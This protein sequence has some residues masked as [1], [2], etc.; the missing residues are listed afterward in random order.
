M[1]LIFYIL[2]DKRHSLYLA[3]GAYDLNVL[4]G[5]Q[6]FLAYYEALDAELATSLFHHATALFFLG[7]MNQQS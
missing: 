6:V 4:Y 1:S 2:G 3:I 5:T 7:V